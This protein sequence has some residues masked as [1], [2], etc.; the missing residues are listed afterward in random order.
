MSQ[1]R[2]GRAVT[3]I[4]VAKAAGVSQSAVS[5][6]FTPGTAVS[7]ATRLKVLDAAK[8]L[9]YRPNAIARTLSTSRSRIIGVVLSTLDN[10]FYPAA[11]EHLSRSLQEHGLHVMLFFA[12]G[13][14]VDGALSQ[15]LTYQLDGVVIASATLSSRL[16]RECT[17]MGIPVVM[18][19]RSAASTQT[20]SV[21]SNNIEGGRLAANHL[22]DCG[23]DRIAYLA[24]RS[25]SSTNRDREAGVNLALL[26]RGHTLVFREDGSYEPAMAK[27]ATRRLMSA[28]QPPDGLI[29]ASDYMA[30]AAL[31]TLRNE[32]GFEVPSQVCVVSFDDVPAAAWG[33]YALTTVAQSIPAM[34]HSTVSI[35]LEQFSD[36]AM[37][38]RDV[39]VSSRL[40]VRST[41]SA[42]RVEGQV[43]GQKSARHAE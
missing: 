1:P 31:D 15:L 11:I 42:A 2:D 12:E 29:V 9:G 4:D 21:T 5:R 32:L 27:E 20:S 22:L 10:Q 24:G 35:L 23:C 3:S 8:K 17:A 34:V 13:R 18:F 40:I 43:K 38:A 30:F 16:A 19:N 25:D 6:T 39:I 41:T 33:A 7:E 37:V 26:E 28:P 36:Q 14:D